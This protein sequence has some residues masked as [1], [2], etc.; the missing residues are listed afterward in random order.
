MKWRK[1]KPDYACVFVG[2]NGDDY[3]IYQ[4]AWEISDN[5]DDYTL[6]LF[7]AWLDMDGELYDDYDDCDFDE[8]LVLKKLPT[9]GEVYQE[10][11]KNRS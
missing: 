8:Y 5:T 7:L 10:I 2:K 4:F 3:R 9:R 11:I 1:T 6:D